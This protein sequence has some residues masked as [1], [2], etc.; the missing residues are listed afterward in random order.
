MTETTQTFKTDEDK[1][2]DISPY[3]MT[4]AEYNFAFN[5]ERKLRDEDTEMDCFE[6]HQPSFYDL[7]EQNGTLIYHQCDK[8]GNAIGEEDY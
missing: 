8:S 5:A 1:V 7:A 6:N 4:D 3:D 2:R